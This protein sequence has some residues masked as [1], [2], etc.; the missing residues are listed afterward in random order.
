MA[1]WCIHKRVAQLVARQRL[2]S[3]QRVTLD[4]RQLAP[5]NSRVVIMPIAAS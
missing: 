1:G 5:G 2:A 4:T 3:E